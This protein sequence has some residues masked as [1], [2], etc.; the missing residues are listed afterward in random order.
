MGCY[1]TY[2]IGTT[3]LKTAL[4][5][6]SGRLLALHTE[7]YQLLTPRPGWAEMP[8]E[9]YWG[10]A[11]AGTRG[12]LA[13]SGVAP[14]DVRAIGFSSQGETFIP[15]DAAGRAQHDAIVWLD[16]RGQA[17]ADEWA[18]DWLTEDLF[19]RT[20]GYP[21]VLCELT[22]F[23]IA[24]WRRHAP[25]AA[26]T[27]R[28]LFLPDY[29]IYR[30]TGECATDYSIALM[31]GL[32]DV[33]SQA[34][35]RRTL[36]ATGIDESQLP[37]VHAPGTRVGV[38]TRAAADELG[39]AFGT[40]V[41]VGAND[42][43]AGAVGA[44]NV[45]PGIVSETTGTALAVVATTGRLLDSTDVC[46]GR[47]P[48]PDLFYAMAY[49]N[50]AAVALTWLRDLC[51]PTH[52]YESLLREAESVPLGCD[53]LTFSPHLMGAAAPWWD[54][55]AR[56]AA[57]GLSL[58]HTRGHL[59]RAVVESCACLL[60]E[61]LAPIR[62]AGV[63]PTA[64]RSLGGASRSDFWLQM[65]A[66]LLGVS[67]ERP[68]CDAAA[69]VG[70]A[71]IAAAGPGDAGSLTEIASAWYRSDRAFEPDV[72]RYAAYGEVYG[73]Y[74]DLCRKLYRPDA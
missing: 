70:A 13:A 9:S 64:V 16:Q 34:W 20:T 14:R 73:R 30:M 37:P 59:A 19:R 53:G 72:A 21:R 69:S 49:A 40:P 74:Q 66:D 12:V 10:A 38:L 39:L 26:S 52:S 71:A 68:A 5:S 29:L 44:G 60:R 25:E 61:C 2:D 7:E 35:D 1:L 45:R 56:G 31:S 4:V 28:Y 17:I 57:A 22:P 48:V 3:S 27:C 62:G 43:L 6:E 51:G 47:H 55:A 32:Y 42:Q 15:F 36:E 65:K 8:A 63:E 23:K 67:V 58:G 18:A 54:P 50:T 24:W 33:R 46:V 11:T 41:S